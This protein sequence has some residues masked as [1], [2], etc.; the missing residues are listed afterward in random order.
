[1]KKLS[2]RP[3]DMKAATLSAVVDQLRVLAGPRSAPTDRQLLASFAATRDETA[4]AMLVHRHG[5]MV[6]G[7][8]RRLL[9][10]PGAA[11]DAFQ[12]VFLVLS[13]KAS[14]V[15]WAESVSSWL[16]S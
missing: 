12:A 5:P 11:D 4:F 14:A 13:R 3:S 8:C 16:H 1:M 6:L 9:R 2:W 15:S 10:D 7:T